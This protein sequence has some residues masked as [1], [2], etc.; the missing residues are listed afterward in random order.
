MRIYI[1]CFALSFFTQK[2]RPFGR[3]GLAEISV[4]T[5]ACFYYIIADVACQLCEREQDKERGG[6]LPP[7]SSFCFAHWHCSRIGLKD[8]CT[9]FIKR[10]RPQRR[11]Q[12][13]T[14]LRPR[15]RG[16]AE[17]GNKEALRHACAWPRGRTWPRPRP[18]RRTHPAGADVAGGTFYYPKNIAH[19]SP[20]LT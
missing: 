13:T 20:R 2:K 16:R 1:S 5:M 14:A 6:L 18:T 19:A 3:L 8:A 17:D 9:L 7:L 12:R 4:Y 15:G 11:P 10:E